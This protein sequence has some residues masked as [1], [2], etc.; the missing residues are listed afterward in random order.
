MSIVYL[1]G[2]ARTTDVIM[3]KNAAPYIAFRP[4]ENMDFIRHGFSTRLGGVSEGKFSSMNLATNRGDDPVNVRKNYELIGNAL[5]ISPED[6]VYA[7]QTHTV[8]VLHVNSS[9]RGMGIL[10][11]R[12]FDNTDALITDEP[13]V[14]LVCGFADCIPLFFVDP[15]KKA[16][17][18]SHSGWRGTVNNI[19]AETIRQMHADFGTEPKDI[20]AFI[21]PG[22][23]RDHYE[24]GEDVA[25]EFTGHYSSL[26]LSHILKSA[27]PDSTGGKYLLNLHMA[28]FYNITGTG[29]IPENV[30]ITDLC[31]F[32]N[33][34]LFFSH[35]YTHG[36]RGGM[37]GFLELI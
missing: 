37:C 9:H 19:A 7:K 31:T 8:N 25:S 20:I 35:R 21:G 24:V 33:P 36:E 15:V 14:C 29:V 3:K 26:R 6:M 27:A 12:D 22:I 13:G 4:F 28:C 16:I 18:L 10:R 2:R 23:C 30:Y 32:C 11:D 5:G 34:G 1:S 17:G